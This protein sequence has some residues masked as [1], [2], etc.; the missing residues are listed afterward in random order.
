MKR[1]IL[2]FLVIG[3]GLIFFGCSENNP[4]APELNQNDQVTTSLAKAK[5]PFTGTSNFVQPLDPGTTTLLPNGKTLVK[6][7][8]VEWYD[9]ANDLRVTGQS[10]WYINSLTEEDGLSAKIWG[11][12]EIN[13]GVENPGDESRGKWEISWH[14]WVTPTGNETHP[15]TIVAEAVGTGKEGEVKGLVAK[16]TYTMDLEN[17]FFYASEGFIIEH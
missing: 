7:E 2:M 10:I 17:G 13:V 9:E 16:W 5:T 12:A 1:L 6:G 8:L 11:K 15:F 4:S 14:G 3:T